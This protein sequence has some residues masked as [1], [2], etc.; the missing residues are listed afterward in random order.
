MMSTCREKIKR[1]LLIF[2]LAMI[3]LGIFLA[4]WGRQAAAEKTGDSPFPKFWL[5]CKSD[6]DCRVVQGVCGAWD[7][8]NR[9][10]TAELDTLN[11]KMEKDYGCGGGA[12][13]VRPK[14]RAICKTES[15]RCDFE[16]TPKPGGKW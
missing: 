4:F 15:C 5:E 6:A 9:R 3:A 1:G 14:P 10:A 12:G 7:C 13:S 8:V 11:R 16:P 2:S